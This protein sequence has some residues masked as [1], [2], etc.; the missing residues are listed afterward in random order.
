MQLEAIEKG[1]HCS[2]VAAPSRFLFVNGDLNSTSLSK[3]STPNLRPVINRHVQRWAFETKGRKKQTS[4]QQP[5]R[6]RL[7]QKSKPS[8]PGAESSADDRAPD[9]AKVDIVR[10]RKTSKSNSSRHD[11]LAQTPK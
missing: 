8:A 6:R 7:G 11:S 9:K 4:A 2:S 1:A 10:P 3:I 5:I